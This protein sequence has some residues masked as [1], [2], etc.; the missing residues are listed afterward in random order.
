[1]DTK[2]E[3]SQIASV[4]EDS[5]LM[6]EVREKAGKGKEL[7]K[8]RDFNIKTENLGKTLEEPGLS[9]E[10]FAAKPYSE[11]IILQFG[12]PALL[13]T[14]D[15]FEVPES[16]E[17]R[18]RLYPTKS[19]IEQSLR[20]V[21]RIELYDHPSF[22]WV[23][24]GWMVAENIIATNRHVAIE[25]A[26][27]KGSGFAFS[28]NPEGKTIRARIDFKE[29]YRVDQIFETAVE[30]VIFIEQPGDEYPDIAL[31]KLHKV[32]RLPQPIPL[33]SC[34][35]EKQAYV[36]VVGYP[37]RDP[38][39]DSQAMAQVFGDIYNV[40][41][42]SPGQVT[43]YAPGFV[44]THDCSTLGGNSGSVVIDIESGEAVGIHFGGRFQKTNYAVTAE[45]ICAQLTRLQIQVPVSRKIAAAGALEARRKKEK[46]PIESY[47]DRTGY[48]E[49]FLGA[50]HKV[51][52]P[53][54]SAGIQAQAARITDGDSLRKNYLL[55]YTHFSIVLNKERKM[56]FYTACNIDGSDLW[57]IPRG[58]DKWIYDPRI[59]EDE[60]AGDDLY[61]DNDLD[62][63]HLVRRL[64]PV[65]GKK[66]EA[67]TANDDTFHFTNATPQHR[68]FN[69][70]TWQE[71]EEYILDNA[72]AHELKICLFT[73]PIFADGDRAYRGYRLP[74]QYWKVAAIV[75]DDT[76]KL[77]VTGYILS[78]ADLLTDLEFAFG[79]FKSYQVPLAM[80]EEQTGLDFGK[81]KDFDPMS[82]EEAAPVR[83]LAHPKYI[84]L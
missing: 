55:D 25:F 64:D 28:T 80:I 58:S 32:P 82:K 79:N 57:R 63:G 65:W 76:E 68:E 2:K 26:R 10:T 75:R 50:R 81:L 23:G 8:A 78:Q 42:L 73:G 7:S 15:G 60:Q 16:D 54:L 45:E 14:N 52:L 74:T 41:R 56:A 13:V 71:I 72:G 83:Q 67:V 70:K 44:M 27:K 6:D 39:N 35:L 29:E 17:W 53:E 84:K 77:S 59:S 62:R 49:A 20:S 1:M 51:P 30:N 66:A 22:D 48:D 24:T 5:S 19:K 34:K 37:A 3:R 31:L 43:G 12:R 36:A 33:L 61:A 4:L 18:S 47:A 9:P 69:Q 38:R 46:R 11:A 40:K 21:G